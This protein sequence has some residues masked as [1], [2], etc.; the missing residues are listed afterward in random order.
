[1]IDMTAIRARAAEIVAAQIA[2]ETPHHEERRM[3]QYGQMT[4]TVEIVTP[5]LAKKWL[6]QNTGN[7]RLRE[8]TVAQYARDMETLHW[9]RKPVAICFLETG[10]LGNGQH[11]LNAIVRSGRQQE[12]LVARNVPRETI[13]AMDRGLT[14]TINDVANFLG[15]ELESRKA[16]VAR[17]IRYGPRDQGSKSFNEL[18]D[19]Y[20]DHADV[21]DFVCSGTRKTAGMSS[22]VLAVC[23]K[24]AYSQD[25]D[26]I[27][28]F[29][30][31]LR[32]GIVRGEHESA[33]IR[34]RDFTRSLR[35]AS[36]PS[37]REE[38][39]NKTMSALSNFLQGN[40]MSK[41]YGTHLDLFP[42]AGEF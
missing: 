33:A 35:G 41:L 36:S 30:E 17:L 23:A 24:A 4:L 8:P 18:L 7:R 14:R 3:L 5:A 32:T 2:A 6:E 21:V 20:Q 39:Y 37:V 15:A 12:L 25:R 22:A 10:A 26:K 11:T 9:E 27:Q 16:G 1:M 29:M 34:L 38:T 31:V 13:A 19:A 40:P 42:A 28:R